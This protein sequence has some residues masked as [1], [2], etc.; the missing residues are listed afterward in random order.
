M[1]GIFGYAGNIHKDNYEPAFKLLKQ[2]GRESEIRGADS[3]GFS[4]KFHDANKIVT[5]KMPY[6]AS[7]FDSTSHKF[8]KLRTKMPEFFI[9][10][11]RLGT[12]S[13][14]IINNNNHPFYGKH[15]HMIHNGVVP[16]WKNIQKENN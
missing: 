10:H 14:P 1:C 9:G 6:R 3:T 2:L 15:Y 16:S 12:G 4:C 8:K 7:I 11:T 5:D 13:S